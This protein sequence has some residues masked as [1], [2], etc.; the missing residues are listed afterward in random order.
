MADNAKT[1]LIIHNP[2]SGSGKSS[3]ALREVLTPGASMQGLMKL[4]GA[5]NPSS[6]PIVETTENETWKERALGFLM[7]GRVAAVVVIGGDGTFAEAVRMLY[8]Q[9]VKSA[10]PGIAQVAFVPIPAGRG[11]DFVKTLCGFTQ[12]SEKFWAWADQAQGWTDQ[13]IDLVSAN[14]RVFLN[15]AS[16]GYGGHVVEKAQSRNAFWSKSSLVYQ[17][18]GALALVESKE[19]RCEVKADGETVYSGAFF[20]GF[21][22]N[23]KANG[24]GLYWLPEAAL[25]DGKMDF[26]VFPK[27]SILEMG[28]TIKEVKNRRRPAF[29]HYSSK[30]SDLTFHFDQEVALELDGDLCESKAVLEF[31]ALPRALR[32][33]RASN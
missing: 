18:E 15:M 2:A 12:E 1:F 11:N 16:I 33:W 4:A 28:K 22:G 19:V 21:V 23:G 7:A 32:V 3:K 14:G 24:S 25:S 29:N 20:G 26:I 8:G 9:K 13:A 30:A 6:W 27:P 10:L 31:H 5:T 17:I